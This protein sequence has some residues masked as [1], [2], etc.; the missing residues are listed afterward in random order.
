M[1]LREFLNTVVVWAQSAVSTMGYPGLVM[2]MFLENVFPP[3]PSEVILP[4]AGSLALEGRF[5]LLGVTVVGAAGSVAGALVFYGVGYLFGETRVRV[6]IRNYGRWL[7]VSEADFDRA[8][9]WFDRYGERVIFFGRMVPIVR[10]LISIPAG[11]ASMNLGTFGVYTAIGTGMW[12]FLLAF[13]GYLLGRSWPLV[14]QWV[15][16]YEKAALGIGIVALIFFF[17]RRL[18]QNRQLG[19]A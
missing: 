14:S 3:I 5:T 17:A 4:L 11:I 12:S 2:V 6:L 10:S 16:R 15:S 18:L 7:M 1:G 9:A 19:S 13:A 8:L